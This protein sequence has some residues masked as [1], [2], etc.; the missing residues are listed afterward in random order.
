MRILISV[1]SNLVEHEELNNLYNKFSNEGFIIE[2]FIDDNSEIQVDSLPALIEFVGNKDECKSKQNEVEFVV[3]SNIR[4]LLFSWFRCYNSLASNFIFFI[5]DKGLEDYKFEPAILVQN[6]SNFN[7]INEETVK[8]KIYANLSDKNIKTLS[9]FLLVNNHFCYFDEIC[10]YDFK[11]ILKDTQQNKSYVI[12]KFEYAFSLSSENPLEKVILKEQET[13]VQINDKF[14][15]LMCI[16]H[17]YFLYYFIISN[18]HSNEI[19]KSIK[20]NLFIALFKEMKKMSNE[21]Q[22]IIHDLL[23]SYIKKSELSFKE[24]AYLISL[25]VFLNAKNDLLKDIMYILKADSKNIEY[26]YPFL[27]NTFFYLSKDGLSE[28]TDMYNDRIEVFEKILEFYKQ[29]ILISRNQLKKL[30]RKELSSSRRKIAIVSGQLLSPNHAP[31]LMALNRGK[32]IREHSNFDVKIFVDD[33]FVYRSE[34]VVFP[35]VYSSA[36]ASSLAEIHSEFL[37]GNI[38]IYYSGVNANRLNRIKNFIDEINTYQ[39]DV[40]YQLGNDYSLPTSLLYRFYPVVIERVGG[41]PITKW[42]DI[43][44]GSELDFSIYKMKLLCEYHDPSVK[45]DEFIPSQKIVKR[46]NYSLNEDDFV[47]ITVGNRLE[48]DLT[49]EFLDTINSFLKDNKSGKWLIVGLEYNKIIS[50][51]FKRLI[52]EK[53]IVFIN[54]EKDLEALYKICDV[55][56]NPPRYGGGYSGL[57]AMKMG[58]PIVTLKGD[59]D[60]TLHIGKENAVDSI[61]GYS[62]ELKK[63]Y[64]DL[65]Y[66]SEKSHLLKKLYNSRVDNKKATET[67]IKYFERAKDLFKL[68]E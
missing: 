10:N 27:M 44:L 49:E 28:Y 31:T 34:E 35:Y 55:Y 38:E 40:I 62:K 7:G 5:E 21:R 53:K 13:N 25:L 65:D 45:F 4:P 12:N 43:Y 32:Y 33:M 2:Q 26:H 24:K 8:G 11:K 48:V 16:K 54:Y 19:S 18:Y 59:Y 51:K 46:F 14:F 61:Q 22:C 64:E 68:R 56:V 57:L 37:G 39:P 1:I 29:E 36:Q 6:L 52:D 17:F 42:C 23:L 15:E 30:K 67:Y 50:N 9:S 63:L 60:V 3:L 66:R 47:L 41:M 58:I 20:D